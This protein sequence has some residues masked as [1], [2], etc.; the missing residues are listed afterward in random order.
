MFSYNF[1]ITLSP[2]EFLERLNYSS[3]YSK[4]TVSRALLIQN[5][6]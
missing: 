2:V 5:C 3:G 4:H 1:G 6:A